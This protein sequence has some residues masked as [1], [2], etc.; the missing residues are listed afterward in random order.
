MSKRQF[1]ILPVAFFC[2]NFRLVD[3]HSALMGEFLWVRR[4]GCP[5]LNDF[6]QGAQFS[7]PL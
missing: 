5:Q 7:M 2:S 1:I 4:L 6:L 3:V